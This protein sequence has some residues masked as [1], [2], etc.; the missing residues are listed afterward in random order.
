MNQNLCIF[1]KNLPE[2]LVVDD[3]PANLNLLNEMLKESG[4]KVRPVPNGKLAI[5]AVL[6]KKPDLILLDIN[7]PEMDGY[8]VCQY[9]KSNPAL[10]D[11]PVLFISALDE[12]TDKVKAFAVGGVDYVTKPF[13]F[14]EVEA[15]VKTH[16]KLHQLQLE[17]EDQNCQIQ[18]KCN[19]LSATLADLKSTQDQ[20]GKAQKME[21]L[22]HLTAGV[23]HEV[24]TPL[25]AIRSSVGNILNSLTQTLE[26]IP[27]FFASLDSEEITIF[28]KLLNR[29]LQIHHVTSAKDERKLKSAIA[30]LLEENHITDYN[31]L[32]DTLVEMGIYDEFDDFLDSF[33]TGN[34]QDI[35]HNVY[36]LSGIQRSALTINT[37][38]DKA[39]KV[40]FALKNY[41]RYDHTGELVRSDI[42]EG[43]ETIL[44]LYYNQIKHNIELD[45][46]YEPDLPQILCHPDEL[47][48][49]WTN[50]IHNAIQAMDNKGTLDIKVC[51]END[52]ISVYIS[53]TGKGIPLD[54][55][56]KIFEPFFTTK[57]KGEG[58]GLGLDIVQKII[59]RHNG[60]ISFES[61]PGNTTFLVKL[62]IL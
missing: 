30:N 3:T 29:S 26:S 51:R 45:K 44:T 18:D 8:E 43:I 23:A 38:T 2:I 42:C 9:F 49:V 35:V 5:Q 60:F 25:G 20:L 53:D 39:S 11:I 27:T 54:L 24:N 17:L 57:P 7:M 4:Y 61:E 47:N 16:L 19:Q 6:N 48:Q 55:K 31:N 1:P 22:G 50:I 36:K 56:E 12:S 13:Q 28:K 62:P 58:T 52:F 40:V 34:G 33:K 37:A 41:A 21:A 15:R 32:A 14:E 10:K 59:A 46:F